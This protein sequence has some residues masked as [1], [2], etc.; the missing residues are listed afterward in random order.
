MFSATNDHLW[1]D[2]L[3]DAIQTLTF[4]HFLHKQKQI[5]ISSGTADNGTQSTDFQ[6]SS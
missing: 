3:V 6:F 2:L 1:S 4:A 5:I